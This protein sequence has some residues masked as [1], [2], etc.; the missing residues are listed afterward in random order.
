VQ[1]SMLGVG[2][3]L[4]AVRESRG[5][6][7]EE[8][9]RDTRVRLEF[10]EAIEAEAFEHLHGDVHVRGCLRTFATYLRLSPDKVVTAYEDEFGAAEAISVAPP[11]LQTEP[12]LGRR[13]RRDDHRLW[14]LVAA[15]TLVL[16]TA[17]G[18]LSSRRPSPPP[19]ELAGQA[20]SVGAAAG[21]A[22]PISVAL[23]A[24][25][26]VDVTIIVNGGEPQHYTLEAGEGRSFEGEAPLTVRLSEG[27][28][29]SVTV[30][31]TPR[32]YVGRSGEPWEETYSYDEATATGS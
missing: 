32:G 25:R 11:P 12:V 20:I 23:L 2:S 30:N 17:F 4:R 1:R 7:L 10:L 8:A 31:G 16:A 15:T 5:L 3:A 24:R 18:V 19:A 22:R 26:P 29:T 27:G 28:I 21:V 6:S 14:I 13:R 9:A